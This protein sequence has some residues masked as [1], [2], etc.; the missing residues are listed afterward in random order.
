M[1]LIRWGSTLRKQLRVIWTLILHQQLTAVQF[2]IKES[3]KAKLIERFGAGEVSIL[4]LCVHGWS[5][6]Y[7]RVGEVKGIDDVHVLAI[8]P[9]AS[10]LIIPCFSCTKATKRPQKRVSNSLSTFAFTLPA[11]NVTVLPTKQ[12]LIYFIF[13]MQRMLT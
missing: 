9:S 7:L 6:R 4:C 12:C 2:K 10:I 3:P 8:F 11:F 5:V 1:P 13:P